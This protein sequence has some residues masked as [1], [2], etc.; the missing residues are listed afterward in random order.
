M[1]KDYSKKMLRGA[2]F[3]GEDLSYANFSKSDLRGAD[4]TNAVLTGAEFNQVKTGIEPV[5]MIVLSFF[6]VITLIFCGAVIMES[7]S[8]IDLMLRSENPFVFDSGV[9]ALAAIALFL[10]NFIEK[11]SGN[12]VKRLFLI[13]GIAILVMCVV[14][15]ISGIGIKNALYLNA[16]VILLPLIFTVCLVL[17]DAAGKRFSVILISVLSAGGF[18]LTDSTGARAGIILTGVCAVIIS[19]RAELCPRG[20]EVIKIVEAYII[21]KLGTSFRNANLSDADFSESDIENSDFTDADIMY[22]NWGNSKKRNCLLK[23]ENE[24][25]LTYQ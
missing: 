6:S 22:V 2:S 23:E 21:K 12:N 13:I 24:N 10:I 1:F 14:S 16:A 25:S 11:R 15:F 17:S 5:K 7:G 4:F 9:A 19:R 20:F 18:L 3:K 8:I